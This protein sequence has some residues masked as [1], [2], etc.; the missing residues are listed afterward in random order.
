M[1]LEE[2]SVL[3]CNIIGSV[4]F[5]AGEWK[6]TKFVFSMIRANVLASSYFLRLLFVLATEHTLLHIFLNIWRQILFPEDLHDAAL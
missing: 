4:S 6:T 3:I 5:L 1:Y 2:H